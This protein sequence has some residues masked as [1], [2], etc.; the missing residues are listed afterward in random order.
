[1][2]AEK[3]EPLQSRVFQL[4]KLP[5]RMAGG[6]PA[7]TKEQI[8]FLNRKDAAKQFLDPIF[9]G[10]SRFGFSKGHFSLI[11]IID[12]LFTVLPGGNFTLSTWTA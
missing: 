6:A 2:N 3:N 9:Q 8:V 1:M 12:E 10:V 4:T 7:L 5:E 11:D